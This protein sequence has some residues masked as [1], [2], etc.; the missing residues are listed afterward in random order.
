MILSF[1]PVKSRRSRSRCRLGGAGLICATAGLDPAAPKRV[2]RL[3][4]CRTYKQH[5]GHHYVTFKFCIH[6]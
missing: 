3:A 5:D 1:G 6:N 4:Q 2:V